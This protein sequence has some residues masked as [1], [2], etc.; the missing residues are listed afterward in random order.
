MVPAFAEEATTTTQVKGAYGDGTNEITQLPVTSV[1][2]IDNIGLMPDG[3]FTY[4]LTPTDAPSGAS[5]DVHRGVNIGKNGAE[6]SS[7]TVTFESKGFDKNYEG[8]T[9]QTLTA[10]IPMYVPS[11]TKDGIYCYT[12]TQSNTGVNNSQASY[13]DATYTVE[14]TVKE[15]KVVLAQVY[16]KN[17]V[18]VEPVY[19]NTISNKDKLRV[20][21]YVTTEYGDP[22]E[23]TFHVTIPAGG[24]E[25]GVTLTAGTEIY[26]YKYNENGEE[27]EEVVVTVTADNERGTGNTFTLKDGEYVDFPNL[28]A[29]LKYYTNESDANSDLYTS[30]VYGYE[31]TTSPTV[32]T[33]KYSKSEATVHKEFNLSEVHYVEYINTRG[34]IA[35]GVTMDT[36]PYVLMF[37]A[38]AGLAVL[39]LAKKKIVR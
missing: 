3:K 6:T 17:N 25:N 5:S 18:K 37:V 9:Q 1:Y 32:A 4:T 35:T 19:T 20:R 39:S 28:P 13:D 15:E 27:L 36:T 12:L 34:I 11:G 30:I 29:N 26:G 22:K 14:L 21:N 31:K 38:A 24:N 7:Q 16:N 2:A 8:E 23:F 10:E 33:D